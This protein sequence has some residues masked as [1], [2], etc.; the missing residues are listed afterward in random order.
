[1]SMSF[2]ICEYGRFIWQ[3]YKII[4]MEWVISFSIQITAAVLIDAEKLQN[5]CCRLLSLFQRMTW[6]VMLMSIS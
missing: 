1:M 2:A 6:H 4:Q 5:V 3:I